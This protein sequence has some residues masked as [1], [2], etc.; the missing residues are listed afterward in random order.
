MMVAA[1]DALR[2]PSAGRNADSA[3]SVVLML[4]DAG[5]QFCSL[6]AR[7]RSAPAPLQGQP[8][9]CSAVRND[10]EHKVKP[11]FTS[12]SCDDQMWVYRRSH[13]TLRCVFRRVTTVMERSAEER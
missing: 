11:W 4:Q 10:L 7:G 13:W 2:A 6:S 5:L 1:V 3:S 12:Q 9:N 8:R